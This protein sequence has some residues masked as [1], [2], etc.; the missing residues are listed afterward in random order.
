M[1]ENNITKT[2]TTPRNVVIALANVTM[3]NKNAKNIALARL[4]NLCMSYRLFKF[5]GI[6][7]NFSFS[8]SSLNSASCTDKSSF[9]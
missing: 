3:I 6:L 9:V 8:S 5:F 1:D 2:I 7:A 4:I